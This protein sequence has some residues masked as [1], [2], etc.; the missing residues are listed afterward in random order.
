MHRR[1]LHADW[2]A[3]VTLVA[4]DFIAAVDLVRD[5]RGQQTPKESRW[6]SVRMISDRVSAA[7]D[8]AHQ[9]ES[10]RRKRAF[11]KERRF[12]IRLRQQIENRRRV[13]CRTVVDRQPHLAPL[14]R[15]SREHWT[16]PLHIWTQ[17]RIEKQ[18]VR[19]GDDRQSDERSVRPDDDRHE[20]REPG[21]TDDQISSH[22]ASIHAAEF[23]KNMIKN[24]HATYL[25]G[26]DAVAKY[27]DAENCS[28]MRICPFAFIP[29]PERSGREM[30]TTA[31][32]IANSHGTTAAM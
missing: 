8:R 15:K 24:N 1:I 13:V 28:S 14:G 10:L 19:E 30:A 9:V 4:E 23:I 31:S 26:P 32:G 21:K 16:E 18:R 20:R 29:A 27:A 5:P 2:S 17:R 7:D 22:R 11:Q 3:K 6:V 12:G 25:T